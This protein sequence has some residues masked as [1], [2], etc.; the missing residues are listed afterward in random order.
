MSYKEYSAELYRAVDNI[1]DSFWLDDVADDV[2]TVMWYAGLTEE[3]QN[4][5]IEEWNEL[6]KKA[7]K[8]LNLDL[9]R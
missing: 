9:G 1:R 4:S 5:D 7:Q 8:I 6:L 3:F 2:E